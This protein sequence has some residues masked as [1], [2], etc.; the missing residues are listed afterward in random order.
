MQ[1]TPTVASYFY[2]RNQLREDLTIL[3]DNFFGSLHVH[4]YQTLNAIFL[5]EIASW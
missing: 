3:S 4:L 1:G 2:M 5:A